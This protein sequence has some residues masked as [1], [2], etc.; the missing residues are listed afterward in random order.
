[1]FN[2]LYFRTFIHLVETGSFTLTAK[3][4]DM[5]QPG[6]SQHLRKLEE[7]FNLSLLERKGRRFELTEAGRQVFDYSVQMFA[8]HEQFRQ[9]LELNSAEAGECRLASIEILGVMLYPFALG[10]MQGYPKMRLHLR[11]ADNSEAIEDL[12]TQKI[13]L[14]LVS[15]KTSNSQLRYIKYL[16]EPLIVVV[17]ANFQGKNLL[18]LLGLGFIN[19]QQG[20][21]QANKLLRANFS[22]EFRST[23]QLVQKS[24]VNRV[25]LALDAVARGLG[26]SVVPR[27]VWE[28]STYQ[29]QILEWRLPVEVNW[30]IYQ[31]IRKEDQLPEVYQQLLNAYLAW[32]QGK[33]MIES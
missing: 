1:M 20:I 25:H 5:T 12:L 30:N 14:A 13:D 17:P 31:A 8:D 11:F 2:A 3:K 29:Q 22:D 24:Y 28:A 9:G 16:E 32:R 23:R 19:H 4:L 6:V 27:N 15:E 33:E 18:D 26:F 10:F 21:E 7:Y